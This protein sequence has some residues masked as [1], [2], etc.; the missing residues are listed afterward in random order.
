MVSVSAPT[1]IIPARAFPPVL[2]RTEIEILPVL[3]PDDVVV[4][5]LAPG[6]TVADHAHPVSVVMVTIFE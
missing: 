5:Q 2:A 4:N 6:R 3:V 1:T